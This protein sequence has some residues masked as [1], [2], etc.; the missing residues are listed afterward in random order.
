MS[1]WPGK[2]VL[3]APRWIDRFSWEESKVFMELPRETIKEAPEYEEDLLL[4]RK[5]EASLHEHYSRPG[6]WNDKTDAGKTSY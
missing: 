5:Y 6:Y 1:W 4:D 2:K 3:V